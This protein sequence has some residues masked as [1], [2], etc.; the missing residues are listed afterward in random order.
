MRRRRKVPR[1]DVLDFGCNNG[2]GTNLI[3]V[4]PLSVGCDVSET[5]LAML[6]GGS[7]YRVLPYRWILIALRRH[8]FDL[9]TSFRSS[10]TLPIP[11]HTSLRS[12]GSRPGGT[13]LLTT[14]MLHPIGSG[15]AAWKPIPCQGISRSELHQ[16]LQGDFRRVD[17]ADFRRESLPN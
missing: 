6:A 4:G 17:S 8:Q 11:R 12:S 7:N 16:V 15:Y 10:S 9:I 2:Y 5:A 14:P 13:A 3:A 1:A